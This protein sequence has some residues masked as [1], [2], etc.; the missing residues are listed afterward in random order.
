MAK[1]NWRNITLFLALVGPGIITASVD[2]DAGGIT[3]Y[4][5]AGAHF[6]YT[7]LWTLIP[8]TIALIIVQEMAS[9]MGVVTGKG[10]ADLIRENFGLKITFYVIIGLLIANFATTVAEFAGIAAV[11][12]I[13]GLSKY[14]I[15]PLC[16]MI[17]WFFIVKAN[18]RTLEK[19]FLFLTFFYLTY[20]I[21][22]ILAKPDWS[23]ALKNTFVPSFQLSSD[24]LL[25]MIGV[26]GTTITPWMQF[27]LQSS[28]VEKGIKIEQ[29]AYSKWDVIIG[30]IIT[31][32][33]AF[34]I[35]IATAATLFYSGTRIESASDAAVALAPLAGK[36]A[37]IL[38]AVGFFAA[39]FFGAAILPIST[40]YYFSEALGF[41]SGINKK[42]NEAPQFYFILTIMI[43]LASLVVL[44]PKIPLITLMILSQ[45]ING[46]ILPVILIFM[47]LLV[48][49]KKI[50]G[51]HTNSLF[52]NIFAWSVCVGI[53]I[54]T[55]LLVI[56]TVFPRMFR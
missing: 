22:G 12:E 24:Y 26:I 21:S 54:L 17:I 2:N 16:A 55:A 37:T 4:S 34:F 33:V 14:I 8:I 47:L 38:F 46:I 32:I 20:I 35:I 44:I 43:A 29:Y 39:A 36:Y 48:N 28:I 13:F 15:V 41:E 10:L 49:N 3:T 23:L 27:Y 5:I 18:Y 9:R 6:G 51:E 56:T 7:L 1:I 50:M 52:Y 30:C 31:D 53:I 11:S 40:A 19:V 45:V 42:F 25:V